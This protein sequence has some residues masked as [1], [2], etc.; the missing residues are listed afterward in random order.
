MLD[1]LDTFRR[2][3]W[4]LLGSGLAALAIVFVS[5]IVSRLARTYAARRRA[6]I[7]AR[8]LPAVDALLIPATSPGAME[9]LRLAPSAHHDLIGRLL[10]RPLRVARGE[11]VGAIRAAAEALGHDR[12]WLAGLTDHRWWVRADSA[13]ALGLI[14][15]S[16]ALEGLTRALADDSEEV[17]AAAVESLGLL[18]D[19]RAIP[20]LLEGLASGS[21]QQR[22]RVVEALRSFGPAATPG[23]LGHAAAAPG[24]RRTVAGVLGQIGGADALPVLIGWMSDPDPAVR[25]ASLE[26]AGTLGIDDRAH[27][28]VLRALEDEALEVRAMAARALARSP[29]QGTSRY[30]EPRLDDAWDVAVQSALALRRL[31]REGIDVLERR[32]GGDGQASQLAGQILWERGAM[33][34]RVNESGA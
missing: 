21:R 29:R 24:D 28:F 17:R 30:L 3:L 23:L 5:L 13:R 27:Y 9:S 10:L 18:G 25:A 19:V 26:A 20:A 6:R 32:A 7:E 31:G 2:A 14:R 34:G 4:I 11:V 12:R 1:S 33:R 22:V 8:Y 15:S 16:D